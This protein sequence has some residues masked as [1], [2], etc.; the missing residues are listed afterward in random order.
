MTQQQPNPKDDH[1]LDHDY[2]GIQEFDNPLPKWWVYIM[3]GTV[4]FSAVYLMNVGPV[5]IGKG[6]IAAYESE[7]AAFYAAHPKPSAVDPSSLAALERNPQ[8]LNLGKATFTQNC[9]ACHRADGGG[10]I[11]P[12]LTDQYWIHG[13]QITDIYRTVTDGVMAKGMPAWGKMLKPDQLSAVVAYVA[14]LKGTNPPNPKA[15]QGD[16]GA[17]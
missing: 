17:P 12:N 16:A 10:M 2:D 1:L 9:A 4:A 15:P 6:R 14:T 5:G 13:P 11:G 8:A 7:M 3:W